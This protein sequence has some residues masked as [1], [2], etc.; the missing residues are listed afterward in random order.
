[1]TDFNPWL[2][3]AQLEEH[4]R[5]RQITPLDA[6]YGY[7]VADCLNAI[8][9]RA[10]P[11]DPASPFIWGHAVLSLVCGGAFNPLKTATRYEGGR[12]KGYRVTHHGYEGLE[13]FPEPEPWLSN[14]STTNALLVAMGRARFTW[15]ESL[16]TLRRHSA[17]GGAYLEWMCRFSD[18]EKTERILSD[19][20]ASKVCES[21]NSVTGEVTQVCMFDHGPA[22]ID[23]S[24]NPWTGLTPTSKPSLLDTPGISNKEG[25]SRTTFTHGKTGQEMGINSDRV[26]EIIRVVRSQSLSSPLEADGVP[27]V[28]P[29]SIQKDER[30]HLKGRASSFLRD[31][32]LPY[33][34]EQGKLIEHFEIE[35]VAPRRGPLPAVAYSLPPET[36]IPIKVLDGPTF[37]IQDLM[38][39]THSPVRL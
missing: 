8:Q 37:T 5:K 36:P 19:W 22:S 39:G 3:K 26:R 2:T 28:S 34:V 18:E 27:V 32:Y 11:D 29:A 10:R 9:V 7:N 14:A 31:L 25:L 4:N 23:P 1:M 24:W 13:D 20:R 6:P 16:A 17:A 35:K 30:L 38:Q 33:L 21:I 12:R 15:E